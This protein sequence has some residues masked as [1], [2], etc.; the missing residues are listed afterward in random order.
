M[1]APA[2]HGLNSR[3]HSAYPLPAIPGALRTEPVGS[4][5]TCSPAPTGS[6]DD[7]LVLVKSAE[8]AASFF[9]SVGWKLG[10]ST[11]ANDEC[12]CPY[13]KF[14]SFTSGELNVILTESHEFFD[15]FMLATRVARKL[16]LLHKVHRIDLFQAI[17]YG[18]CV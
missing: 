14:F 5:A 18:R 9:N 17:L 3:Y 7:W 4:R 12:V 6:D 15:R 11:P 16:N 8:A 2:F 1:T 10:G 13:D